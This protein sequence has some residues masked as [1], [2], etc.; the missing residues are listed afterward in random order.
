MFE[1][2]ECGE[3]F[4]SLAAMYGHVGGKHS[5]KVPEPMEIEH[6]TAKGYRMHSRR[7]V[8]VCAECRAAWADYLRSYRGRR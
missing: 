5:R 4:P 1:C 2:D 6:G 7:K 3:S 8:P